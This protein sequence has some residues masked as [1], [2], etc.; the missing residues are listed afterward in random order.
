M[1]TDLELDPR[2]DDLLRRTFD[3]VADQTPLADPGL[4]PV[5]RLDTITEAGR[6]RWRRPLGVAVVGSAAAVAVAV[7]L[8]AGGPT[9]RSPADRTATLAT[10]PPVA[11]TELPA[12]AGPPADTTYQVKVW[13]DLV[14][15]ALAAGGLVSDTGAA[16]RGWTAVPPQPWHL[17]SYMAQAGEPGEPP[18]TL[19][20][21][22]LFE[23][24]RYRDD[25]VWAQQ[26]AGAPTPG[27]AVPEGL[28]F[29]LPDGAGTVRTAVVVAEHGMA[30]IRVDGDPVPATDRLAAAARRVAAGS[31]GFDSAG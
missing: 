18:N 11:T 21:L 27:E 17:T 15:E 20:D 1:T 28:L 13:E 6:P 29:L 30:K 10:A 7:A 14:T 3:A 25:P 8:V 2:L 24:G 19:I 5:L 23:P 12:E 16:A 4:A 9:D 31:R 26:V 22:E